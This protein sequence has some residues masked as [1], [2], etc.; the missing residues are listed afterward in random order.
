MRICSHDNCGVRVFGTDKNTRL[1]YCKSHQYLRTDLKKRKVKIISSDEQP[2]KAGGASLDRWFKERR[3][4]MTGVCRHCGGRTEK[5][6]DSTYKFSVAHIL[7]KRLFKSVA[8]HPKNFIELCFHGNSC[9]TN[10]DNCTL[11][12][13]QLN[14]FAE[15]IEKFVAMYP[16]IAPDERRY[17]PSIL[18]EYVKTDI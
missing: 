4:E 9:H 17:I 13:V 7:P 12:W 18:L 10:F 8:T 6:N 2:K 11:E 3:L 16:E 5:K 15:V 1:G 14:C